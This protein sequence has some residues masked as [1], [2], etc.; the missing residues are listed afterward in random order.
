MRLS[1]R[2]SVPVPRSPR[3]GM[4]HLA[5][6]DLE[7]AS[8]EEFTSWYESEHVPRMLARPGWRRMSRY[9][10]T[11]GYPL[12]S[13]YELDADVAVEPHISEAPFR[14]GRFSARG[15]RNYHAR[16]WRQIHAAGSP[17]GRPDW[18]NVV[19]VDIEASHADEFSRWYNDVHVPEILACPGWLANRR[20]ECVDG[21]PRFLAVYELEDAE[22]PFSS[23]E[24]A[25]AA[26]W[27][28]HVEH[29]R[30]FHGFRVY[31]RIYGSD[32]R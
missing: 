24:W 15:I 32:D 6:F 29:I 5:A 13:L 22:R 26:G 2:R 21:E 25:A 11:D 12:L 16:T 27:D 30:G 20:Y 18:I 10:C 19:T 9:R 7:A 31:Q 28:E 4:I 17:T 8:E 14:S 23:P 1:A 3:E